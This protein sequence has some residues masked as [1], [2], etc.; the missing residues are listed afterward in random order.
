MSELIKVPDIGGEGEVIEILVQVGDRIEVEQSLVTLES[1]KASM[2]VPSPKAGTITAIKV[3]IGD[4]LKEGD[5]LIELEVE[6]ADAAAEQP[7]EPAEAEEP[8]EEK[9]QAAPAAAEKPAAKKAESSVQSF[10]IPDIGD[11]SAR[12]I[13]LLVQV[14]DKVEADQSLLTLES[15]K[16]SMEIPSPAAGVIEAIEVK[17]EQEV[18]TGDLML[19]MRVE[20]EAGEEESAPAA[21]VEEA[22]DEV[23]VAPAK[24]ERAPAASQP[25][26]TP[27][28]VGAPSRGGKKVHAGPAVR[29]L[30]REFGI[31]L[32]EVSG[33]GPRG[34]ILKEDVQAHV[35]AIMRQRKE[36]GAAAAAGG[37]GIPPVPE[38]DFTRFGEVEVKDMTRLQQMGAT[39]LHRSWLNVPHV[40]Q[41]DQADISELEDFRK[42]QK[43]V[44]EKAG[45]KLTVLPFLLKACAHLLREQPNFN[46]SLAANG[47]QL[48]EKKYVHIGF[49]VDTPDGLLV[50]VIRDVDRK[51][52]LELAAEAAALADK[53]R[54]KKLSANDM[55]GACF[56]I[57]SLGHIGG[58]YFTP[59]VNTPEVAILGVSRATMQPVWD[60]KAFQP[61]LMLPLSLSY[62]HRAINGAAAAQFTRR[63]GELL[64]DIRSMLL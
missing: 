54:N 42:A 44:A 27:A 29:K 7:A 53:A 50:P 30:A 37:A 56:T 52:L 11:G 40:T 45:V 35:Q 12:V 63:L 2:E 13:E 25:Q 61:R 23:A 31:D 38:V 14:G 49:A 22:E 60:G 20:G 39:N 41:F 3:N 33:T 17:L 18:Q 26:A 36:G 1:D 15:D 8:A 21:I 5:D 32:T 10:N 51:S 48:I 58:T 6:G 9:P 46:V 28:P 43:A 47:K 55:Q 4:T 24:E 62:D 59:I 57:S 34:R 19:R 16:A 64:G